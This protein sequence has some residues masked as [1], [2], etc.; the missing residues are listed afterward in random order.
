MGRSSQKGSTP[1]FPDLEKQKLFWGMHQQL[2][3]PVSCT[4]IPCNISN[5]CVTSLNLLLM[6]NFSSPKV[7]TSVSLTPDFCLQS[8]SVILKCYN[9]CIYQN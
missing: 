5:N 7:A 2:E 1:D 3:P 8:Q 4:S 6:H 9:T